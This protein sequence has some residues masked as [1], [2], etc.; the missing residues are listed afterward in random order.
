MF[1]ARAILR[2]VGMKSQ[3][4]NK[5]SMSDAAVAAKTG[6]TWPQWFAVLDKAGAE[7]MPHRDIAR[8]L[9]ERHGVPGWWS[10]MVTVEYERARGK[11][12]VYQT[13]EG[14]AASV[15]RTLAASASALYRAW[16]DEDT[17]KRWL[18]PARLT[19]TTATP[20]KSVHI[21]CGDGT[22][23]DVGFYPRGRGKCQVAV[24]HR[25]LT[26]A[27]DVAKMKKYWSAALERLQK[28]TGG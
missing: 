12:A 21:R 3:A 13:T 27:T 15:S 6:K 20:R 10:Q 24:G 22:R 9:H 17:R 28:I 19:I 18:G 23:V 8:M 7:A 14:Y 11:R 26:K 16:V 5:R 1:F 2:S 25:K 4:T